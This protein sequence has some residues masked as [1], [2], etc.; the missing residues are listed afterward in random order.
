MLQEPLHKGNII[1]AALVDLCGIPLAETVG[2]YPLIAQ[3]VTDDVQLLLYHPFC[4]WE[5]DICALD[6][7]TQAVVLNV[8]LNHKWD[9]KSPA[10]A[11]LLLNH[12]QSESVTIPNYV[13][14]PKLQYITDPQSQIALQHKDGCYALIGAASCETFP[15]GLDDLPVL[16]C[17]QCFCFLIHS[18]LPF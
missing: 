5:N 3:I 7:V 2:T 11:G 6:P 18:L 12:I 17:G 9:S 16:L 1:P 10:F 13:T 14:K 15:H 4:D 8:L